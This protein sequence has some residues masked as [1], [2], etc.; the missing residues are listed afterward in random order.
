MIGIKVCRGN[1]Y[2]GQCREDDLALSWGSD[3][4]NVLL[5]T[6]I[7]AVER[8]RVEIDKTYSNRINSIVN[9]VSPVFISPG[10]F[11]GINEGGEITNGMVKSV[12]LS[13]Q[14]KDETFSTATTLSIERNL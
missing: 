10:S 4:S 3:I 1:S 7:V 6:E 5:T 8:G 9:L 14:K 11:L 13:L 2:P 12:Q